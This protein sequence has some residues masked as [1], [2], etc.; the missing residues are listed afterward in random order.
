MTHQGQWGAKM[1]SEGGGA[2]DYGAGAP[3][4]PVAPTVLALPRLVMVALVLVA[5]LLVG[6][7]VVLGLWLLASSL[8]APV[9][10]EFLQQDGALDVAPFAVGFWFSQILL[11]VTL[12]WTA[13]RAWR[14]RRTGR[15]RWP[16]LPFWALLV[17][18]LGLALLPRLMPEI[19]AVV[20]LVFL[21]GLLWVLPL[22]GLAVVVWGVGAL[23]RGTWK[24]E[25]RLLGLLPA[26]LAVDLSAGAMWIGLVQV[27]R[28]TGF[29]WMVAD[30]PKGFIEALRLGS[31]WLAMSLDAPGPEPAVPGV[32]YSGSGPIWARDTP[33]ESAADRCARQLMVEKDPGQPAYTPMEFCVRRMYG[34]EDPEDAAL[35]IVAKVCLKEGER[36]NAVTYYSKSCTNRL[37]RLHRE[38]K[39]R[40]RLSSGLID[41]QDL[42][43]DDDLLTDLTQAALDCVNSAL[44]GL[45]E[46][47]QQLVRLRAAGRRHREIASLLGLS[48][49][50]TRKRFERVKARLEE[51]CRGEMFPE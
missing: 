12:V 20:G 33:K 32:H 31:G 48:E 28:H 4:I 1:S 50:N 7:P 51:Q 27:V 14:R 24:R 15:P 23:I 49:S 39:R 16:W 43:E 44:P 38:Q 46:A 42:A 22:A 3:P 26:L 13:E 2:R 29:D 35:S 6:V 9:L 11:A 36:D 40:L 47:D 19:S 41:V 30:R 37:K 18:A 10:A 5:A 8:A 21:G 34:L 25:Q 45:A 17:G